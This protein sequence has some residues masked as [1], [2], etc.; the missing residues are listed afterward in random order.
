MI[1]SLLLPGTDGGVAL[2]LAA[3][4]LVGPLAVASL[5]RRGYPDRAWLVAGIVTM[6]VAWMGVRS[7]H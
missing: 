6:W 3:T 4:A 5:A 2:Q 1:K 7:L